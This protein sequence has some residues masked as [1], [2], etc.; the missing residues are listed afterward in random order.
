MTDKA[1]YCYLARCRDDS[2]YAGTTTDLNRREEEHNQG[3]RA[4]YTR[5]RRPVTLA[6]KDAPL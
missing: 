2:L 5:S 3:K 4:K 6:K 1:W